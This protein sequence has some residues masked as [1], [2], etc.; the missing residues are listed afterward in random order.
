MSEGLSGEQVQYTLKWAAKIFFIAAQEMLHLSQ[1]WNLLNAIGGTPYYFR[2]NFPQTSKYYPFN[3]PLALEPFSLETLQRFILYELPADTD[4]KTF[5]K[6]TFGSISEDDYTYKTVG[7]LYRMIREGFA[8]IDENSLFIGDVNLQM[9]VDEID[10]PEII[11]VID[12]TSALAAIDMI[13]EQGEGVKGHREDSH[14]ESFCEIDREYRAC[15]QV[16]PQFSPARNVMSNPVTYAKGNYSGQGG[17]VIINELTRDVSD[18]FDDLYNLMLRGLQFAFSNANNT[19][20]RALMARVSIVL[21][22]RLIK[23]LGELLTQLP[24]FNDVYLKKAGPSFALTRH[25]PFPSNSLLTLRLF[26]ERGEEIHQRLS[27]LK[28]REIRLEGI[29][30]ALGQA[31]VLCKVEK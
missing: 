18:I 11:K 9:G 17:E 28:V 19:R 31:L 29:Y 26:A 24:A 27:L 4:E 15:L 3:V 12:G 10:F 16:Q 8:T 21:M 23:P 25:V 2:P 6:Q 20:D 22:V 1:V 14:Y 30:L 5:A 7:E 13:T